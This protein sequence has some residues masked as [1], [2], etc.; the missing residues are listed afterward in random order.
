MLKR[1]ARVQVLAATRCT[2]QHHPG[3]A[4][5]LFQSAGRI[6]DG[7][8]RLSTLPLPYLV[9]LS[10]AQTGLAASAAGAVP[11][12]ALVCG[13]KQLAQTGAPAGGQ[14]AQ[15][16]AGAAAALAPRHRGT[17]Q[18][19]RPL[20]PDVAASRQATALAAAAAPVSSAAHPGAQAAPRRTVPGAQ[21]EPAGA[22]APARAAAAAPC[23]PRQPP[24]RAVYALQR[25]NQ[26]LRLLNA[27]TPGATKQGRVRASAAPVTV[28]QSGKPAPPGAAALPSAA[29]TQ[30]PALRSPLR[31]APLGPAERRGARRGHGCGG[32]S[33]RGRR[34]G[35]RHGAEACSGGGSA[36]GQSSGRLAPLAGRVIKGSGLPAAAAR[37]RSRLIARRAANGRQ[38]RDPPSRAGCAFDGH[39]PSCG[40][41]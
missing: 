15:R 20:V 39:H 24:C 1:Q 2:Q 14:P 10:G 4:P 40:A 38:V 35:S 5:W 8:Y 26:L 25:P 13:S 3:C 9:R 31:A 29:S 33:T 34:G 7:K 16:G 23:G 6:G 19:V 18:W 22:A 41:A 12:L 30:H 37:G 28:G 32:V 11:A 17:N 27:A 21:A 36:A